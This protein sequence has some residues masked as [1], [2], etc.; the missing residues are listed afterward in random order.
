[1]RREGKN[2]EKV[3]EVDE[4][5]QKL[6]QE[7]ETI[8]AQ[9][10]SSEQPDNKKGKPKKQTKKQKRELQG[11]LEKLRRDLEYVETN[12][13]V[14]EEEKQKINKPGNKLARKSLS[15]AS[16]DDTRI[17]KPMGGKTSNVATNPSTASAAA[18]PA[19][20]N[21]TNNNNAT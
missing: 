19:P 9:I 6:K 20:T 18:N 15:P 10:K 4:E 2:E 5:L 3:T 7:R 17:K 16:G 8:L 13:T 14:L 1:M 21:N 12:I 11:L